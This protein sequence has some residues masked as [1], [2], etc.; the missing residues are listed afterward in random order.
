MFAGYQF[1]DEGHDV[2]IASISG[3]VHGRNHTTLNPDTDEKFWDYSL[4]NIIKINLTFEVSLASGNIHYNKFLIHWYI[5]IQIWWLYID[6]LYPYTSWQE[7]ALH[8]LPTQVD[9]VIEKTKAEQIHYLGHSLGTTVF[10]VMASEVPEVARKVKTATL[11][12]PIYY[13][14]KYQFMLKEGSSMYN[15]I[16]DTMVIKLHATKLKLSPKTGLELNSS[17]LSNLVPIS[18]LFY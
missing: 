14:T 5:F 10:L 1:A 15:M 7:I 4:V 12:A 11:L 13:F 18:F 6:L 17:T 8:D 3:T 9:Y 16:F 2:W